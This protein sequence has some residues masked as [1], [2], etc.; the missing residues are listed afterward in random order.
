MAKPSQG[1]G[2]N[3]DEEDDN[4]ETIAEINRIMGRDK[5]VKLTSPAGMSLAERAQARM[6]KAAQVPLQTG[7]TSSLTTPASH[8]SSNSTHQP[9][10]IPSNV[11]ITTTNTKSG[12]SVG[13]HMSNPSMALSKIETMP[14]EPQFSSPAMR[15]M[16]HG[17][18]P[19]GG[20][21][22]NPQKDVTTDSHP[23]SSPSKNSRTISKAPTGGEPPKPLNKGPPSPPSP[24]TTDHKRTLTTTAPSKSPPPKDD[25][26]ELDPPDISDEDESKKKKKKGFWGKVKKVV[27]KKK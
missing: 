4:P 9:S 3:S 8:H 14:S 16:L 1:R 22:G 7:Q 15:S 18:S 2:N 6:K 13:H 17:R 5:P 26:I 21:Y 11:N 25:D 12:P 20:Y 27:K 19:S 23:K 10:S 24:P